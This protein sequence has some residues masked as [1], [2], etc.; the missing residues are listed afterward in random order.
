VS[1]NADISPWIA[2]VI[3]MISLKEGRGG[4]LLS[5]DGLKLGALASEGGVSAAKP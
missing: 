2:D 1:L 3:G 4:S 5:S